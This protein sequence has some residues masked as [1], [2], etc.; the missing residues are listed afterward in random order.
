MSDLGSVTYY[1]DMKIEWDCINCTVCLTQ[2]AY[3][4]K[5]LNTFQQSQTISVNT[6]MNFDA[7][8]M[9]EAI[10]Q[11]DTFTIQQYQKTIESLMYIMLQ[12]HSDITFAVSTVSQF[13]QN[14]NTSH[15]NAVKWIFRYLTES[16]NLDV[17]YDI[18][19]QSLIDYTD[20]NWD[21]CHNTRKFTE[22]YLF[23]LYGE[24]ISWC[25]KH[26]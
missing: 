23:L 14:S 26:Q 2:M 18:T 3:I 8:L 19:D 22:T 25:L 6:S 12:T 11:T 24:P 1:L 20:I 16:M 4:N 15:Y 17:I 5:I 7:V 9:K 21:E 13:T 10:T